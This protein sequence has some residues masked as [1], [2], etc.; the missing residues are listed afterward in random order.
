MG[1]YVMFKHVRTINYMYRIESYCQ[2]V[3][4]KSCFNVGFGPIRL[5]LLNLIN[6]GNIILL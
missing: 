1:I 2:D 6:A 5:F 3:S 4:I